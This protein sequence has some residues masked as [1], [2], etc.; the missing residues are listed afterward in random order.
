[1]T[2][3]DLK[4]LIFAYF[5]CSMTVPFNNFTGRDERHSES[6][7]AGGTKISVLVDNIYQFKVET[8]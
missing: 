6:G 4:S 5:H 3:F 7:E 8:K 1:M 2:N